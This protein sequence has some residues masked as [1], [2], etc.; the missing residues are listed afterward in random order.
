MALFSRCRQQQQ[1]QQQQFFDSLIKKSK[2][3]TTPTTINFVRAKKKHTREVGQ[4]S[5]LKNQRFV[6]KAFLRT[7]NV[8]IVQAII[9]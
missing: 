1:Q 7:S 8:G 9:S 3:V 5:H 4:S 2:L 6:A